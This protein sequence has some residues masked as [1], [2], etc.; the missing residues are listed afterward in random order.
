M[1]G[2]NGVVLDCVDAMSCDRFATACRALM[3]DNRGIVD[4]G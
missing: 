2:E 4:T 3:L 1:L